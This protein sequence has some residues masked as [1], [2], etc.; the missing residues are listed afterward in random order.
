MFNHEITSVQNLK[1][2]TWF[3]VQMSRC[4]RIVLAFPNCCYICLSDKLLTAQ[5]LQKKEAWILACC[6]L[7]R[8]PH[9]DPKTNGTIAHSKKSSTKKWLAYKIWHYNLILHARKSSDIF[10]QTINVESI[11]QLNFFHDK[12]RKQR[13]RLSCQSEVRKGK[14]GWDGKLEKAIQAW[15]DQQWN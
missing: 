10:R 14:K 13:K 12:L 8:D 11:L 2:P 1:T 3:V 5:L 7:N 6:L 4:V 15:W 9:I